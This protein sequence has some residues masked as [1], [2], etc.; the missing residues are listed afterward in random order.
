VTPVC[1]YLGEIMREQA[2]VGNGTHILLASS[3][4]NMLNTNAYLISKDFF[5]HCVLISFDK[6]KKTEHQRS[7]AQET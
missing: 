1:R 4:T 6:K 5:L 7:N 2:R 3:N